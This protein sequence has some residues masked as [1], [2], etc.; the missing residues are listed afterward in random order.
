VKGDFGEHIRNIQKTD[1]DKIYKANRQEYIKKHNIVNKT[2]ESVKDAVKGSKKFLKDTFEPIETSLKKID[3]EIY[4]Q[5]KKFEF[6]HDAKQVK[7]HK[8][9]TDYLDKKRG[10]KMTKE[11]L[12]DFD[13]ALNNGWSGDAKAMAKKH[14]FIN[15]FN[16]VV[17]LKDQLADEIG[18]KNKIENHFPRMIEDFDKFIDFMEENFAD[19]SNIFK[20]MIADKEMKIGHKIGEDQKA[21]LINNA[22]RGYNPGI[23][24]SDLGN[25]RKRV[26]PVLDANFNKFYSSSDNAIVKYV[27]HMNELIEARR[28]FGK[29]EFD[30]NESIGKYLKDVANEKKLSPSQAKEVVEILK[31]R[32]NQK[33][34]NNPFLTVLRDVGIVTKLANPLGTLTQLKDLSFSIYKS[35]RDVPKNLTDVVRKKGEYKLDEI[36]VDPLRIAEELADPRNRS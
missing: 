4:R 18:I 34:I 24:L 25:M 12:A 27:N 9:L 28:F 19:V 3:P 21:M 5:V 33:G 14:G 17:K 20:K 1:R 8:V 32:F 22:L 2:K 23:K 6:N 11:E 29:G 13:I 7:Y 30:I 35:G 26:I 16:K 15:E 36:G 31:A 10:S